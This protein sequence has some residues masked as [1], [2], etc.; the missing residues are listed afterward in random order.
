MHSPPRAIAAPNSP[1]LA[2]AELGVDRERRARLQRGRERLG[3]ERH[4]AIAV[5]D[6][7]RLPVER[8]VR[9]YPVSPV[10]AAEARR[11]RRGCGAS[12]AAGA[13]PSTAAT[14]RRFAA[15]A[16]AAAC[17]FSSSSKSPSLRA[18]FSARSIAR[19][20]RVLFGVVVDV[21]VEP[22]HLVEMRVAEELLQRGAA[23]RRVHVRVAGSPCSRTPAPSSES[24]GGNSGGSS[25]GAL[26]QRPV[27]ARARRRSPRRAPAPP[28]SRRGA[29]RACASTSARGRIRPRRPPSHSRFAPL[30][31]GGLILPSSARAG[32][33]RARTRRATRRAPAGAA[34]RRPAR[35]RPSSG[36][37]RGSSRSRPSALRCHPP[38]AT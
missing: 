16:S 12:S 15:A 18:W 20:D 2:P 14:G 17:A 1:D 33:A 34:R 3:V 21:D 30:N 38:C 25:R 10:P 32:N 13:G 8:H 22:V 4:R 5:A 24:M 7:Q 36:P 37:P 23:R 29:P 6:L 27:P 28:A 19:R 11:R 9:P 35:R 26:G 31:D